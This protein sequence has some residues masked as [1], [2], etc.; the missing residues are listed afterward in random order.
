MTIQDLEYFAAVCREHSINRA[1][2]QLYITPSGPEQSPENPGAG[3]GRPA[4]KPQFLRD[5]PYRFRQLP[6]RN[7]WKIF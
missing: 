6:A 5:L 3:A 7:I 4:F 2:R 1:A